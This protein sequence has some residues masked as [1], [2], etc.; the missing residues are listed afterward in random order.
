MEA[1]LT[2][3]A[4]S[5]ADLRQRA[6]SLLREAGWFVR[7]Q[8]EVEL[9]SLEGVLRVATVVQINGA[10]KLHSG[11]YFVWSVRHTITPSHIG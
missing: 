3:T 6:S 9:A 7:C 2:A 4:D 11:K 5:V 8:G 10:G 1:R